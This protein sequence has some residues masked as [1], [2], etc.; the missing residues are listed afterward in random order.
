LI[1]HKHRCIFIHIP[2][3]AGTPIEAD[4]YEKATC[5][6]Y[7]DDEASA[8]ELIGLCKKAAA[9]LEESDG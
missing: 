3:T 5:I 1:S 2:R 7:A 6:A 8:F 4:K 9:A